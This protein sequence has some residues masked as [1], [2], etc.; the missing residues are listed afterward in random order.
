MDRSVRNETELCFTRPIRTD[1]Q[2]R[3]P[4]N[5]LGRHVGL[6]VSTTCTVTQDLIQN[7]VRRLHSIVNSTSFPLSSVVPNFVK[8]INR[9]TS[10]VTSKQ[11]NAQTTSVACIPSPVGSIVSLCLDIISKS[12]HQQKHISFYCLLKNFR[13]RQNKISATAYILLTCG[14]ILDN[15]KTRHQEQHIGYCVV[16]EF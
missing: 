5:I 11:K 3:C 7:S 10:Q 2:R 13:Q 9:D 15:V 14:R 1:I 6:C 16:E 12:K 8:P 4:D